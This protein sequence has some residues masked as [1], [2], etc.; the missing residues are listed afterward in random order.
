MHHKPCA[1]RREVERLL[2]APTTY[3]PECLEDVF[4]EIRYPLAVLKE[5]L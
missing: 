5:V 4:S 2:G 3:S 1:T